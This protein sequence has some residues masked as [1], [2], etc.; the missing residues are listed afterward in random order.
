MTSSIPREPTADGALSLLRE[1]YEFIGNRCR[2][3]GTDVFET[4]VL[5]QPAVC[6]RG[7]E[8]AR[9]FY[10]P[11]RFTRK[12]ALPLPVLAL[13]QDLGSVQV[14]DD[15]AHRHRKQ[16]FMGLMAPEAL[17]RLAD[18]TADAWDAAV[19]RW[20]RAGEVDVFGAG[21]ARASAD[22]RGGA[23]RRRPGRDRLRA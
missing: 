4:R 21:A 22:T 5:L 14:L 3:Y 15:A 13:M 6:M 12:R 10:E 7:A 1:G 9:V 11:G 8:A 16:M 20:Q 18:L 2:R 19:S 17:A 23:R